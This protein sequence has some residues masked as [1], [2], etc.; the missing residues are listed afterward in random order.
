MKALELLVARL[1]G[2][3]GAQPTDPDT[4]SL[5]NSGSMCW[6]SAGPLCVTK[7]KNEK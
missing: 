4:I 6:V 1:E 5:V 3:S 7:I 2:K